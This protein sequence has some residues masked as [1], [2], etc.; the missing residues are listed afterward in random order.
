MFKGG[1]VMFNRKQLV[2][3]ALVLIVF[4]VVLSGCL[5][6]NG[7]KHPTYQLNVNVTEETEGNPIYAEITILSDKGT[8][9]DQKIGSMVQFKLNKGTYTVQVTDIGFKTWTKNISLTG[10]TTLP[11]VL[12]PKN[13][14]AN[15]DFSAEIGTKPVAGADVL[16]TEGTWQLALNSPAAIGDAFVENGEGK[17]AITAGAGG[18]NVQLLNAP[19]V[20]EKGATYLVSFDARSDTEGSKIAFV[21]GGGADVSWRKYLSEYDGQF[22]LTT[23]M[24]TYAKKFTVDAP[25]NNNARV[26]I[27]ILNNDTYYFDHV[28]LIKIAETDPASIRQPG[29]L[30]EADED[31]VED[32][33]LIWS[34]E[35]DSDKIDRSVWN[36]EVGNGHAN[37]IPG[38]GNNELQY[39]TDG[40]NAYIEDGK[41][42]IEAREEERTDKHGT[43]SYTSTRMTTKDNFELTYGRVEIRAKLPI[44]R[45]I[46][47]AFWMLGR[48]IDTN[49]WPSCGEIDIMEYLGHQPNTVYGTVHGPVSAG[50]GVGSGYTLETGNFN[51]DFHVFAMEW[52]PDEV[53]FYVDEQLYHVVNKYEI[54][55]SDWVFDKPHF[56]IINLAVGG[57]WP[58]YPDENTIFPQ[59]MEIDYI[60]VYEDMDPRSIDG[61]EVWDCEYELNWQPPAPDPG[62]VPDAPVVDKVTG[63]QDPEYCFITSDPETREVD[64]V[65][66]YDNNAHDG[67]ITIDPWGTPYTIVQDVSYEGKNC[68]QVTAAG[69]WGGWATVLAL[70]GDVYSPAAPPADFP[71]DLSTYDTIELSLAFSEGSTFTDMKMKFAGPEHEFSLLDYGLDLTVTGWQSISVPLLG[72]EFD[73]STVTQIAIFSVDGAIGVDK[74][75]VT[76]YYLKTE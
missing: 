70:M 42:I 67:D 53:E 35:F 65:Y 9:V 76:D 58:G 16:D 12:V 64:V 2:F 49:P 32:W 38:W 44:G 19:V 56:F 28:K 26:E 50:P 13:L 30:T 8:R 66:G 57:N 5:K 33:V 18:Y 1:T 23:T 63:D 15:G 43:Y 68:W 59:R 7:K 27:W 24:D 17:V 71:A 46:W 31:L 40:E 41:L 39:Y 52:D 51:Q 14:V 60:R 62:D 47:P 29:T 55:L 10:N 69:G 4:A 34:D 21:V 3:F 54:G 20:I 61:E 11:V 22:T 37:G 72:F 74:F 6:G 25:T 73:L 45:G 75:Y 36:F 48:D